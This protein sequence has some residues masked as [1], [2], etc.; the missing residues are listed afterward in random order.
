MH[1]ENMTAKVFHSRKVFCEKRLKKAVQEEKVCSVVD[2]YRAESDA[3]SREMW[4]PRSLQRMALYKGVP[5]YHSLQIP[6]SSR[7]RLR[8]AQFLTPQNAIILSAIL[9]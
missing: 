2:S 8:K 1:T 4:K 3:C 7:A 6:I 9:S 5:P